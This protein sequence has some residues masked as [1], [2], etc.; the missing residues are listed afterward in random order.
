MHGSFHSLREMPMLCGLVTAGKLHPRWID[1]DSRKE[2]TKKS[3][4]KVEGSIAN[5]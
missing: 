5:E 1:Y 2:N 3:F 4:M